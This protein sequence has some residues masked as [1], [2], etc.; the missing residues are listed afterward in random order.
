M[1]NRKLFMKLRF[2]DH[3]HRKKCDEIVKEEDLYYRQLP[4][5]DI[6]SELNTAS[7]KEIADAMHLSPPAI[8]QTVQRLAKHGYLRMEVDEND[9]RSHRL[10]LTEKG[11]KQHQIC[12]ARL[13]KLDADIT[14]SISP[15]DLLVFDRVLDQMVAALHGME[16]EE[17]Q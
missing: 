5:L 14:G 4:V 10:E 11:K 16:K 9:R 6:L 13:Q 1:N 3:L 12:F 2:V 17:S 7:Q 8:T 15:A